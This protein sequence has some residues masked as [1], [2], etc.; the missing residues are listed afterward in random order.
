MFVKG[1]IDEKFIKQF[2]KLGITDEENIITILNGFEQIAEI[3]YAW[4]IN[5]NVKN[6]KL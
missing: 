4:Y 5:N 2:N 1:E 3:G 6:R